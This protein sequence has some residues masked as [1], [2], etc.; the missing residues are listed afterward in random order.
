MYLA[1]I[2]VKIS[3]SNF[4]LFAFFFFC[5]FALATF[6]HRVRALLRASR[7]TWLQRDT[8]LA[9]DG[10]MDD[11]IEILMQDIVSAYLVT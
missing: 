4:S 1:Q 6:E 10:L 9:A 2:D 5:V 7:G 8:A 11:A 3:V